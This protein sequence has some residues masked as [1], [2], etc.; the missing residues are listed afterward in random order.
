MKSKEKF[1]IGSMYIACLYIMVNKHLGVYCEDLKIM[2][3]FLPELTYILIE[4]SSAD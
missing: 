1:Y 3:K 2:V 4:D